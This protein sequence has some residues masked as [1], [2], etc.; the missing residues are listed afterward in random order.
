VHRN[1]RII[2][3]TASLAATLAVAACSSAGD[4]DAMSGMTGMGTT[5]MASGTASAAAADVMFAQMMV[6]HH[7]QAV[8]MADLALAKAQAPQLKALATQIKAAQGPEISI[9]NGWLKQWGAP[10]TAGGMDH[11]TGGMMSDADMTTLREASG[12]EFDRIWLTMMIA[13]HQ[14]AI[15]MAKDV[16]SSTSNPQVRTLAQNIVNGQDREI[17]TMKGMLSAN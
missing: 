1:A 11:H 9:M 7:Q 13:H 10:A 16:L 15:T 12:A 5:P 2:A 8:E 14:G 4:H 6:P 3:V 17:A